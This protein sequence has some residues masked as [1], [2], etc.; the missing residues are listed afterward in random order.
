LRRRS[1]DIVPTSASDVP[2]SDESTPIGKGRPTPSRKE[3]EAKRKQQLKP[4]LS[5]KE[6]AARE[7]ELRAQQRA[8][9]LAGDEAALLPRD[10]G[11]VRKAIRDYVDGRFNAGELFLPGA[12]LILLLSFFRNVE[13]QRF[14]LLLW[15]V[16]MVVIVL[17]LLVLI[18][19]LKRFLSQ[20]FDKEQ[21]KGATFYAVMRG[22][23]IRRLRVPKPGSRYGDN[24]RNARA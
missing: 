16:L 6:R 18:V 19:G 11:P 14:S 1:L 10:R 15:F 13:I 9:M 5:R 8:R 24:R 4:A 7:R 23:Q 21:T 22:L 12:I 2:A 20:R 3:S 17:D